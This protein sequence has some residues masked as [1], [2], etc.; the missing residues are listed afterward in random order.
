MQFL[1]NVLG[2]LTSGL[3]AYLLLQAYINSRARLLLWSALC[4]S[5]LTIANTLLLVDLSFLPGLD[6]Y[7]Y[8]LGVSAAAITLLVYGLIFETD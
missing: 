2:V 4:F 5:G 3:C 7:L 6:L 1:I 8:R